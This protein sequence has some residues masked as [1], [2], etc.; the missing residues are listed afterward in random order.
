[1]N[2]CESNN[3]FRYRA[4]LTGFAVLATLS[5]AD[6]ERKHGHHKQMGLVHFGSMCVQSINEEVQAHHV[7]WLAK[8]RRLVNWELLHL[9]LTFNLQDCKTDC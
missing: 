1:M 8:A 3:N 4:L 7:A 9:H 2:P 6:A 5:I